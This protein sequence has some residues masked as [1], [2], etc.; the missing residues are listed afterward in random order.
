MAVKN[1][2]KNMAVKDIGYKNDRKKYMIHIW[3][4]KIQ[5][6]SPSLARSHSIYFKKYCHLYSRGLRYTSL[7]AKR[8]DSSRHFYVKLRIIG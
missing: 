6:W 7:I 3:L 5:D 2:W 1:V 4:Q 8:T